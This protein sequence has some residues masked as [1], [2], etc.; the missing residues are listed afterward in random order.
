MCLTSLSQD[1]LC[2]KHF[3]M[4]QVLRNKKWQYR[5]AVGDD[6]VFS[7][8][9]YC[10][11]LCYSSDWNITLLLVYTWHV[12]AGYLYLIGLLPTVYR[13]IS[14]LPIWK[15]SRLCPAVYKIDQPDIFLMSVSNKPISRR[16]SNETFI[17]KKRI[18]T[19]ILVK[20]ALH[21]VQIYT[22]KVFQTFK[23][24]LKNLRCTY[25]CSPTVTIT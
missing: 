24:S 14:G 6:D 16:L 4:S 1:T 18:S 9:F 5:T 7:G 8:R 10:I 13:N 12:T 21:L 3:K 22:K 23:Y 11:W 20:L 19:K 2:S 15:T 25:F 17:H